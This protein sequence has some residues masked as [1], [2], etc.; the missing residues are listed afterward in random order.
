MNMQTVWNVVMF[1]LVILVGEFGIKRKYPAMIKQY[2]LGVPGKFLLI[3]L[4][5]LGILI[6]VL[7]TT[8]ILSS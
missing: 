5:S 6:I 7:A 3:Q 2:L 4:L 8:P 1:W